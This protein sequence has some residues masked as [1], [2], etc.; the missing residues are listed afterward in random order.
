MRNLFEPNAVEEMK[1]RLARLRLDSNRQWGKMTPAQ[2]MAHY[3]AQMEMTFGQRLPPRSIP[4][5]IFGKRAKAK[6]LGEE[7]FPRNTP[8][9][10]CFQIEDERDLDTER[11]RVRRLLDLFVRKGPEVCTRHSYSFFGPMTLAEY[12]D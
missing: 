10:K 6:I 2:A 1:E 9:D 11:E 3:A 8:T 4:G 5:R 7:P 12:Q